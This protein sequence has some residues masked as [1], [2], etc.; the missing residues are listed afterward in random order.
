MAGWMP[1]FAPLRRWGDMFVM[2][3]HYDLAVIGSGLAGLTL[4]RQLLLRADKKVLL[5]DKSAEVPTPRQKLG[6]S[7]VQ[8]GGYYLSK[9]LDLEEYLLSEQML[10]YNLRFHWK[11]DGCDGSAYEGLSQSYIRMMSNLA[12]YQLNRNTLEAELLRLNRL[13]PG[14]TFQAPVSELKVDLQEGAP[15]QLEYSYAGER[16]QA[17]ADWV[18]DTSGRGKHLGRKMELSRPSSIQHSSSYFWVDGLVDVEKL[19]DRKLD[20]RLTCTSRRRLGHFPFALATNHFV[21]EGWW[22]WVIPLKGHT[23][24]GLVFDN[25]VVPPDTVNT[26]PKLMEWICRE[27]PLLARDLP[28]R[29]IFDHGFLR[30][31]SYDCVQ[32]FYP[33]KWA[34]SGEAGRFSDPLYSPGSDLIAFHN[35]AIVDCILTND[36]AVLSKKIPL[37]E[38]LVRSMYQAYVPSYAISYDTLGDQETFVMK[39]TWEL[40]IYFTFFVFPFINQ[41]LTKQEF[42]LPFL[43]KLARLGRINTNMQAMLS[44]FYQWKKGRGEA[45]GGRGE[46]V[47]FDFTMLMPLKKSEMLFYEVGVTPDE[48]LDL[49]DSH[50]ASLKEFARYLV[51]HTASRVLE[52]PAL[53]ASKEF[54]NS[55]R[56]NAFEFDPAGWRSQWSRLSAGGSKQMW[57]FDSASLEVFR[58]KRRAMAASESSEDSTESNLSTSQESSAEMLKI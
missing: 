23:S 38:S 41:L 24:L 20:E 12:G 33:N 54:A 34:I 17:T 15:H 2:Q 39:Y 21:G 28:Q 30:D 18:V 50:L 53:L 14:C 25:K 46:P 13:E 29:R 45:G 48:A 40:T 22:F 43:A 26:T 8:V 42:I 52:E 16:V 6:E 4:V 27:F 57:S 1:R 44:S 36:D 47:H 49:L 58:S 9:M 37:Y 32:T 19:T 55:V 11:P 3:K 56:L 10:K 31:Y 51:V 7:T 35:T 5:L